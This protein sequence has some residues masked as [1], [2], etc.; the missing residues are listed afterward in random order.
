MDYEYATSGSP[1]RIEAP[2][3]AGTY[4][5]RYV[6]GRSDSTLASVPITVR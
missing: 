5:V 3:E 4:E 6:A 2:E 1:V